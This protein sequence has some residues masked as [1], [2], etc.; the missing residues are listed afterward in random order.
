MAP[1]AVVDE[2]GAF[3]EAAG[4]FDAE[5]AVLGEEGPL[6]AVA[7]RPPCDD[8]VLAGAGGFDPGADGAG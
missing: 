6:G 8:R 3:A 4:D 5:A 1:L 7:V 2:G